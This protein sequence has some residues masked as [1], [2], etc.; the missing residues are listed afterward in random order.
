[1]LII[2]IGTLL[3]ALNSSKMF[4]ENFFKILIYMKVRIILVQLEYNYQKFTSKGKAT[5]LY[6]GNVWLEPRTG[7]L[8]F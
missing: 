6:F 8:L 1:M 7:Y 4:S 3:Q 5:D 2:E